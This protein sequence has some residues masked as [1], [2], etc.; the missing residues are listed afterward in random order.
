M[1]QFFFQQIDSWF[2]R[3]SRSMDGSGSTALESVFPPPNNT[4]LGAIRSS[5]GNQYHA[6]NSTSWKEYHDQ[7]KKGNR[8]NCFLETIIGY[9]DDY[10]NLRVQGAWLYNKE[11]QQLYF[12]CPLNILKQKNGYGFF[13]LG[14]P[15]HCDL[16]KVR[17]P[18]LDFQKEQSALENMWISAND[19]RRVLSGKPP[20]NLID[21]GDII[22][23]DPRLGISRDNQIR[24]TE[25]GK[26]YQTCHIRLKEQWCVYM[27]LE[28]ISPDDANNYVVPEAIIRL[29]G[30]ARMAHVSQ[31]LDNQEVALELPSPSQPTETTQR[32]V[33]Y[34]LTPIPFPACAE[35]NRPALPAGDFRQTA[36]E[37]GVTQWAG[38]VKDTNIDII[39][40]VVG[41]TQRIGG[42]NMAAHQSFPVRSFIPA[43]S[44]WYIQV[45]SMDEARTIIQALH[46]TFLT[47]DKDRALGYGQIVVGLEPETE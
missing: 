8:Q 41:K 33:I 38:S 23:S 26:L 31:T 29:G 15:I 17:L 1:I 14:T 27:G 2:F 11:E 13:T 24:A 30:E 6:Q 9:A 39:S 16:G 43:G 19:L 44:C 35:S 45:A 10:A 25:D 46:G 3:E 21:L 12:P 7:H 22:T 36:D 32:L 34:A 42:W 5:I 4:L 37:H 40:A 28:G 20:K 18:L 47:N